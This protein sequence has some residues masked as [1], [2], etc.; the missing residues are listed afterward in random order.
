MSWLVLITAIFFA[1]RLAAALVAR[2]AAILTLIPWAAAR[3]WLVIIAAISLLMMSACAVALA[4]I[5]NEPVLSGPWF[6]TLQDYWAEIP[7]TT[8]LHV[9]VATSFVLT[10][11]VLTIIGYFPV[12][13]Q[14][15]LP[16]AAHWD[17]R[18]LRRAA[19]HPDLDRRPY[20]ARATNHRGV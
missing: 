19:R 10:L 18:S 4:M 16:R 6:D 9:A 3:R 11:V 7:T 2:S 20:R 12:K 15:Y 5:A 17:R 8:I 14:P 1:V 13:D